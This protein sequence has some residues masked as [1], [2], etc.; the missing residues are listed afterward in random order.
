M[1]RIGV[2]TFPGFHVMSFAAVSV[3]EV[4]NSERGEP[5]YEVH[6]LS[7]NG[8]P[9]RTSAGLIIETERLDNSFFDTLI[10]GGSTEYS[11][12]PSEGMLKFLRKNFETSRR[13]AAT[14]VG[15]F[16]LA[17]AGLLDGTESDN[18]IGTTRA[19]FRDAIRM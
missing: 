12:N 1:Q 5:C 13:I 2:V 19:N 10:V 14:C 9:I 8:G 18:S 11:F 4:A 15:T 17:E 16:T 3:F 6:F 7:E